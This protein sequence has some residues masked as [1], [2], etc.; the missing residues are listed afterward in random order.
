MQTCMTSLKMDKNVQI[1]SYY[2]RDCHLHCTSDVFRWA[3]KLI[4]ILFFKIQLKVFNMDS[5]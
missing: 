1:E 2:S 4:V 3:Y 5:L